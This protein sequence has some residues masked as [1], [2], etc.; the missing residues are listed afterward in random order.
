MERL[1]F[2]LELRRMT[3]LPRILMLVA[4]LGGTVC[5]VRA[6]SNVMSL[7]IDAPLECAHRFA[8]QLRRIIEVLSVTEA[9]DDTQH[10]ADSNCVR[11]DK[12]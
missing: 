10:H 3:V 12:A 6:Q 11:G 8:P 2:N 7:S 1:T 4:R 5:S 9:A